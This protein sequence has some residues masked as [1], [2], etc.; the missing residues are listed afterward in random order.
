MSIVCH[1]MYNSC[2][3]C[4]VGNVLLY[5]MFGWAHVPLLFIVV[6]RTRN[7]NFEKTWIFVGSDL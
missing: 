6:I 2:M 1:Q 5:D 4:V 3:R 7:L